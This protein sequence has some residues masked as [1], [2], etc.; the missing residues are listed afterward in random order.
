MLYQATK[1]E[2]TR[3]EQHILHRDF[4]LL[5]E[6]VKNG[7]IDSFTVEQF[8]KCQQQAKE[9]EKPKTKGGDKS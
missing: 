6:L 5:F 4:F 7:C 3:P 2:K 8:D 1:D 9:A